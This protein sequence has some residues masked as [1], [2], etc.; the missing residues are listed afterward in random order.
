MPA[1]A[2]DCHGVPK[3]QNRA[4]LVV[5]PTNIN[6]VGTGLCVDSGRQECSEVRPAVAEKCLSLPDAYFELNLFQMRISTT[7]TTSG[8]RWAT[9]TRPFTSM[10]ATVGIPSPPPRRR[11]MRH[12]NKKWWAPGP[13]SLCNPSFRWSWCGRPHPGTGKTPKPPFASQCRQ[14]AGRRFSVGPTWRGSS[15][16]TAVITLVSH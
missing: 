1:N 15:Q 3:E 6:I 14:E 16:R 4:Q 5:I 11:R 8:T 12:E 9:A 7:G 13:R 10:T 2:T